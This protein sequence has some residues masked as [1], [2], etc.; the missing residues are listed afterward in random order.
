M[1]LQARLRGLTVTQL[2]GRGKVSHSIWVVLDDGGHELGR[3]GLTG[4]AGA[5]TRTVTRS[6]EEALE[7]VFGEGWLDR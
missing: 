5:M 4:H 7:P 6:C 3:I 2:P 1:R